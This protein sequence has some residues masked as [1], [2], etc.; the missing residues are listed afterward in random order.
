MLQTERLFI[1]PPAENDAQS[2]FLI[3][4]DP[5]TNVHNPHGPYPDIDKAR[6]VLSFWSEYWQRHGFGPWAISTLQEPSK[7]IGYGGL[8]F[9][10]YMDHDKINLGYR[11]GVESWGNG[12]ATEFGRAALRYA[13]EQLQQPEVI[14][15]ARPANTASIRV[16]EKLGMI[17]AGNLDELPGQS[18]SLIFHIDK[19]SYSDG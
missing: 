14:A 18:P 3:Y 8:S 5:C 9:R 19:A 11:F 10:K 4:G 2:L 1:R 17:L 16:L 15:V 13:F 12:Y 7:V 6:S